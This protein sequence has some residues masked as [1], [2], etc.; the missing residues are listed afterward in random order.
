MADENT[1]INLKHYI[2]KPFRGDGFCLATTFGL[3][4]AGAISVGFN[5][6]EDQTLAPDAEGT[7]RQESAYQ[8]V[9]NGITALEESKTTLE[10]AQKQY[11]L[12][13]L[14]G[15]LSGDDLAQSASDISGMQRDMAFQGQGVL[16]D[17]LMHGTTG[18]EADISEQKVVELANIFTE[19]V[20]PTADFGVSLSAGKIAYL[21]EARQ[22][23]GKDGFS[24]NPVKDLQKLDDTMKSQLSAPGDTGFLSGFG[25]FFA[26]IISLA[27]GV[28]KL[29]KWAHYE[30]RTVP[31]RPKKRTINH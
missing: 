13:S 18:A 23:M 8:S 17:M 2:A 31:A 30:P 28:S 10:I 20:G 1:R 11:E 15:D 6:A 24:T 7:V 4:I 9:L 27:I 19:K 5:I 3:A 16:M 14:T 21:D 12:S 22:S 29:Q 26:L 25:T